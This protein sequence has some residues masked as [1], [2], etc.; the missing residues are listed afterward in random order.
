[1][2][3][4]SIP[5]CS[6]YGGK[7]LIE[8]LVNESYRVRQRAVQR[9]LVLTL[10]LNLLVVVIKGAIGLWTGSLS[11]L[12]DALHSVTDSLNNVLGLFTV[13][14]ADPQPD[15]EYPYG[16]QK[17]EA[18]GALG[19][20]AFL[21]VACFEI[22]QSAIERFWH[23]GQPLKISG[24]ELG[25]MG[26]VLVI[27]V[28]VALYERRVGRRLQSPI[29]LADAQHTMSDV[30]ITISVLLGLVGI[31]LFRWQW[32]DGVLSL[33]V[34]V[35][36]FW[37]A[38]EV[39]KTNLPWLVDEMAIA[40]ETIR[41]GVMSVPGVL[42]CHQ[43][44]SRGVLGRQVFIEMHLVVEAEDVAT[45]HQITEAVE[46]LLEERYRPVRVSIHVEPKPYSSEELSYS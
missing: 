46:L 19:I 27:N 13:K 32:L 4:R 33:P 38:W 11:L 21:G 36:V 35:L 42:N 29:L 40:P 16:R 39:L 43:I 2:F 3:S 17:Y 34:A 37:S 15:R 41:E 20:A 5:S 9:V 6:Y 18:V 25:L 44:A 45:A 8:T 30:W 23:Q 24:V 12:A 10:V 14:L 31:W 22:L 1:M 7:E 26:L 28:V